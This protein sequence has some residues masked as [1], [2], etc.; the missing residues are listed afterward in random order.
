MDIDDNHSRR[1]RK[2]RDRKDKFLTAK[3]VKN[4]FNPDT[5]QMEY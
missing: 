4:I 1:L 2:I 5:G 3:L